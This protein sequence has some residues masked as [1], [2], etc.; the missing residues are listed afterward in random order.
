MKYDYMDIDCDATEVMKNAN[1][2]IM[3]LEAYLPIAEKNDRG[4][5]ISSYDTSEYDLTKNRISNLKNIIIVAGRAEGNCRL[6][7]LCAINVFIPFVLPVK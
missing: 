7:Y 6:S 1:L 5:I 2:R 3:E 4:K